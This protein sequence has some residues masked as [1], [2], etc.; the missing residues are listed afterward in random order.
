M[1]ASASATPTGEPPTRCTESGEPPRERAPASAAAPRSEERTRMTRTRPTG[2]RSRPVGPSR[3]ATADV[4][5]SPPSPR[6]SGPATTSPTTTAMIRPCGAPP[7]GP[8]CCWYRYSSSPRIIVGAEE[9][10][11]GDRE[12]GRSLVGVE[13]GGWEWEGS[14]VRRRY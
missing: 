2:S 9:A 12:V 7:P 5:A 8:C 1:S 14:E 6:N 10:G 13:G 4:T 11:G 3:S